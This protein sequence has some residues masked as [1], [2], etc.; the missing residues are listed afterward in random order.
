MQILQLLSQKIMKDLKS[1]DVGP[2]NCLIDEWVRRTHKWNLMKMEK[3]QN[4]EKQDE[5]ILNQAIDNF[6]NISKIKKNSH[7]I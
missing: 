3:L 1:F 6:D 2:G 5:V 7:L 4:Q